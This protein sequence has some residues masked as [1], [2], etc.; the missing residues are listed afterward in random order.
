MG[1]HVPITRG[2]NPLDFVVSPNALIPLGAREAVHVY[3]QRLISCDRVIDNTKDPD[4]VAGLADIERLLKRAD[5][6]NVD[7]AIW[8]GE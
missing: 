6:W 3:P 7:E 8:R 2:L 5:S 1:S 4:I